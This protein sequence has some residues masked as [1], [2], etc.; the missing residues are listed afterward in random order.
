MINRLINGDA[1][2]LPIDFAVRLVE[3]ADTTGISLRWLF[4]GMGAMHKAGPNELADSADNLNQ[5]VTNRLILALA[6]RAGVDLSDVVDESLIATYVPERGF[7]TRPLRDAIGQKKPKKKKNKT[8]DPK[9]KVTG[10]VEPGYHE[11]DRDELPPDWRGRFLPVIGRLSAGQGVDTTEAEEHA[12]GWA[13]SFVAHD[14]AP[15]GA[16]ALRVVGDSML[17]D[18]ADGDMVIV[19]PARPV[20]HGVACVIVSED[21]ERRARLK[22]LTRK[23]K[24]VTLVSTNKKHPPLKIP[25][26][27]MVAAYAIIKHLPRVIGGKRP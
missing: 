11:V 7:Y 24:T 13:D 12:P 10:L 23:G 17:P 16:F 8:P 3:W 15:T 5:M 1:K 9:W 25:T 22:M 26:D 21:G 2:T 20:E 4:L 27:K 14:S 18:Y 6:E 19:D